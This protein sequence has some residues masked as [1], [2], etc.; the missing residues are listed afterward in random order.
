MISQNSILLKLKEKETATY[1]LYTFT[2]KTLQAISPGL[3]KP[4]Y[5]NSNNSSHFYCHHS[6]MFNY[7][8]HF[9]PYPK[10]Y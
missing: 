3:Q 6:V 4:K 10:T 8:G 5:A 2:L 9:L 7:L 1:E